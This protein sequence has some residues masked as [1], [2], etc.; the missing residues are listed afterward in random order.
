MTPRARA[1]HTEAF[2][3]GRSRKGERKV[4]RTFNSVRWALFNCGVGSSSNWAV[5]KTGKTSCSSQLRLLFRLA[6]SSAVEAAVR[7]A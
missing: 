5:A 7:S 1:S 3:V 4:S 2:K 6:S